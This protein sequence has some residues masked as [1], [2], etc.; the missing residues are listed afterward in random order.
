MALICV[1]DLGEADEA[2]S[3]RKTFGEGTLGS[4]KPAQ[5]DT[6]VLG[7]CDLKD[8]QHSLP[9]GGRN[10]SGRD[11]FFP[12]GINARGAGD[13]EQAEAGFAAEPAGPLEVAV[14][15]GNVKTMTG[16]RVGDHAG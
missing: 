16:Q 9:S 5:G 3:A 1:G 6:E 12:Q 8:G 15:D 11:N 13:Q 10:L 2:T 7:F 14:I 4:K